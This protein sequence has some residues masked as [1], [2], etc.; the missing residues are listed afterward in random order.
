M[1]TQIKRTDYSADVLVIG[2]GPAG[3]VA[4]NLIKTK[5]SGLDVLLIDK[6]TAGDSG[7]MANKG[8]GVLQVIAED[9]DIEKFVEF[10]AN[11]IGHFL[12]DQEM[13]RKYALGTREMVNLL[14][15][16]GIEIQRDGNG[17]LI[18][19]DGLPYWHLCGTD[20]DWMDKLKAVGKKLGVRVVNKTQVLEMLTS[21]ERVTGAVGFDITNGEYR[22]FNARATIVAS[23]SCCYMC[24]NMFQ[25]SRGDGI[26][27]AYR[28]GA[29]MRSA[30]FGNMYNLHIVGNS[31][32]M[33]G[34]Q[35][36]I[37][38]NV[39]EN[40]G[41]KYCAD[42]ECDIDI[43]LVVGME[44]E[45]REGKGPC[46]M[47]PSEFGVKN[48]LSVSGFMQ[49]WKRPAA[50]AF[51]GTLIK[52]EHTYTADHSPRP[53]V[54]PALIGSLTCIRV[55]HDMRTNLTGLWAI[56]DTSCAGSGLGGATPVTPGRMRGSGLAW[57]CVSAMLCIDTV[58]EYLKDAK[59]SVTD[60]SQVDMFAETIYGPMER[61]EGLSPR[62]L[63]FN[64][65]EVVAPPRY[66]ANKSED[67]LLEAIGKIAALRSKFS[68]V[69]PKGDW[70]MLGLT[71]DLRNMIQCADI[72]FNAALARKETRGWSVREDYPE[73]DDE[74]F[75]KWIIVQKKNGDM[76][77]STED[78]PIEQYKY[79]PETKKTECERRIL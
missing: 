18:K 76:T 31:S 78:V 72:Y 48:P 15:G 19:I 66:S 63:I 77:V 4:A 46:R 27:A 57:A 69:S 20:L 50:D 64:L 39:G 44:K 51:W 68:E 8:A 23:G 42:Y 5:N 1:S 70:H 59:K 52:K 49:A 17:K 32:Q 9:D 43:G 75:L 26:A 40:L 11:D 33:V 3:Y 2:G 24:I 21:P 55:D 13:L 10:H 37:Y 60:E 36:S 61:K 34:G 53:E 45:V 35:Y 47:E 74:N 71:H 12:G 25:G 28:A 54:I 65:K 73:R 56:G 7:G 79:R 38:N 62:E 6:A 14:E 41:E 29:K 30:E 67:R 22:V 16:W 58:V